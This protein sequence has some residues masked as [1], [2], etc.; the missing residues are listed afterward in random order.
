MARSTSSNRWKVLVI[1]LVEQ[2]ARTVTLSQVLVPGLI[3]DRG[4]TFVWL[5][6]RVD[7]TVEIVSLQSH[8]SDRHS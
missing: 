8:G 7:D 5:G 2:I 3:M 6:Q 1:A 4:I